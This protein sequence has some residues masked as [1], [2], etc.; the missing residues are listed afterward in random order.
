MTTSRAPGMPAGYPGVALAGGP[1]C[2]V[3]AHPA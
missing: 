2:A 3:I 1:A